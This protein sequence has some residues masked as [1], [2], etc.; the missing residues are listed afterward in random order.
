MDF[1][2]GLLETHAIQLGQAPESYFKS[3]VDLGWAK[4][5][6]YYILTDVS[7]IYRAAI[8]LHPAHKWEYFEKK[9]AKHL[10]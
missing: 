6:K 1:M 8:L 2:L 4:L 10:R 7:P 5:K 3:E 9:W